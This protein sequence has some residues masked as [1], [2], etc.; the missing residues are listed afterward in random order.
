MQHLFGKPRAITDAI[1]GRKI[2]WLELFYDLIFSVVL[3]RLIDSLVANFT[4]SG[5]GNCDDDRA[6]RDLS[7][8]FGALLL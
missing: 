1:T 4:W 7:S 6:R 5:V 2:S 3:A 8:G